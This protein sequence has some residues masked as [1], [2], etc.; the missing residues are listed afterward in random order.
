MNRQGISKILLAAFLFFL[1]AWHYAQSLE[2][3]DENKKVGLL[4]EKNYSFGFRL[5]TNGWSIFTSFGKNISAKKERFYQF[6]FNEIKHHK[7]QKRS[8]DF[9][10]SS[11]YSPKPF[12]FGKQNNF[13]A[14]HAYMGRKL[15]LGRKAEKSGI[16]VHLIYQG[17]ISLGFAKPYYID[18]VGYNDNGE[19]ILEQIKYSE[20]TSERFLNLESILGSSGLSKGINETKIYPGISAK[21]GLNFDWANYSETIRAI[22]VGVSLDVYYKSIP[23]MVIEHN[24][25]YFLY[26][27]LGIQFG[28]KS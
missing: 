13:Y 9:V 2:K 12:V 8:N 22:E 23:I 27:Y 28:K 7:E 10:V 21:A 17:G 4:Y 1:P 20:E 14:L 6:E 11:T 25:P 18:V 19:A 5:N 16:E 24:R 15:M 3:G 26:L